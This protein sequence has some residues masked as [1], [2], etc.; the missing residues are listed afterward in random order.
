METHIGIRHEDGYLA[1]LANLTIWGDDVTVRGRPTKEVLLNVYEVKRPYYRAILTPGRRWNP[2]LAMSEGLWVIAGR[3]DLASLRP[4]NSRIVEFSDDGDTLNGAYGYRLK[5]LVPEAIEKFKE[6]KFTRRVVLPI[7]KDEDL[8]KESKDIPCNT[9]LML[10]IRDDQL[11]MVVTNRSNDI[12]WGLFAV[13]LC[14]FS[15][16]QEAMA[17]AIGVA[18]GSQAHVSH[19]FHV[20][21]DEIGQEITDRIMKANPGFRK[22]GKEYPEMA[23]LPMFASAGGYP[24]ETIK[25]FANYALGYENNI[26]YD[27]KWFIFAKEFLGCYKDKGAF[28]KLHLRWSRCGVNDWLEAGRIFLGLP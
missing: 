21:T 18:N 7:Y 22:S 26:R 9:S 6:D 16:L 28:E 20:Y 15:M 12:H 14:Q 2:W 19:S 27:E 10:K 17:A 13:N 11:H 8:E 25:Y 4:Y 3:N 23:P 24:W 1:M 5:D